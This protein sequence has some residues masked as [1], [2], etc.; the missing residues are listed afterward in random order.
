MY[1]FASFFFKYVR[2]TSHI[3]I[4]SVTRSQANRGKR[5]ANA[6]VAISAYAYKVGLAS[7][8]SRSYGAHVL[9]AAHKLPMS[10]AMQLHHNKHF[11]P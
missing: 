2:T 8:K 9:E 4:Q 3:C 6:F 5:P 10:H 11:P 7:A 1:E